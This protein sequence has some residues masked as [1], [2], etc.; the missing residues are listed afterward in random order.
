MIQYIYS[1]KP[2]GYTQIS[3]MNIRTVTLLVLAWNGLTFATQQQELPLTGDSSFRERLQPV[4]EDS[5][6]SRM[7][8]QAER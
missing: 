4:Q 2:L 6:L 1:F 5:I 8:R 3:V 7:T